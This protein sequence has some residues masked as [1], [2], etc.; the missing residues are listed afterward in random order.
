MS[1]KYTAKFKEQI[2]AL[3]RGGHRVIDLNR[4]YNLGH[5]TIYK[6]EC[7]LD[8]EKEANLSM[9]HP[10][11]VHQATEERVRELEVEL[12]KLREEHEIMKAAV[13]LLCK[14]KSEK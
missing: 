3:K 12:S 13:S 4:R 6:W 10:K 9:L 7:A 5:N 8:R 1:H 11:S 2:L 14:K